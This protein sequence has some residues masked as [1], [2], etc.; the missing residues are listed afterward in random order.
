MSSELKLLEKV[1]KPNSSEKSQQISE[2][3][4]RLQFRKKNLFPLLFIRLACVIQN[5]VPFESLDT[6]AVHT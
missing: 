5:L 2:I 3:H 4:N 6:P 1:Q